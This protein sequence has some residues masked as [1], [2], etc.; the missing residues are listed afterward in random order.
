[1]RVMVRTIGNC[2]KSRRYYAHFD[3]GDPGIRVN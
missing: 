2:K 3:S 1:L